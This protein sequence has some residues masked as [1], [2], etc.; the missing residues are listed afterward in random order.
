M[1]DASEIRER[2]ERTLDGV[3]D[4]GACPHAPTTVI[5]LTPMGAGREAEVVREG[6]G[7]LQPLGLGQ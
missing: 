3:I 5:D 1:N 6:R 7:L 4:A 2:F